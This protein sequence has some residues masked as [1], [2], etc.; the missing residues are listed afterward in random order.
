M[1]GTNT[2]LDRFFIID[3]RLLLLQFKG[4]LTLHVIRRVAFSFDPENI[5]NADRQVNF[6]VSYWVDT[7]W[8]KQFG[9]ACFDWDRSLPCLQLLLSCDASLFTNVEHTSFVVLLYTHT[10]GIS[11]IE[12]HKLI[13]IYILFNILEKVNIRILLSFLFI[14]KRFYLFLDWLKLCGFDCE[15]LRV[16]NFSIGRWLLKDY[17]GATLER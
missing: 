11:Y 13:I 16:V 14:R 8:R 17:L 1:S 5:T 10:F 7:C 4:F 9:D 2:S 3:N 6:N 12:L 15:I